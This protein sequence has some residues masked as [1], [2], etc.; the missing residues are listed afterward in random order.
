LSK[1][2]TPADVIASAS[3]P[4]LDPGRLAQLPLDLAL[5]LVRGDH[6]FTLQ[7]SG[8]AN[9]VD[10]GNN[11]DTFAVQVIPGQPSFSD[12]PANHLFYSFIENIA[13]RSIT[14]GCGS[15][16]YCPDQPVTRAQMAVFL[17][18]STR[19]LTFSPGPATGVFGD[20]APGHWAGG[21][22]EQL[23]TDGIT[24]GCGG[25][26]Y[27]PDAVVTRAQMAVFLLKAKYGAT[28]APPAQTGVFNDVPMGHW[29]GPWIER[30]AAEGITAGC[31]STTY[32][33]DNPV[34]RG[35]MTVFLTKTFGF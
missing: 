17:E 29:A 5:D 18:K 26:D 30:L 22:I 31:G 33:P 20:V 32:C 27:C 6:L 7:L 28:Y 3:V 35:Q 15:G 8:P 34:T 4:D 11:S 9:D 23:A 24:A 19:G 13:A 25:G 10:P 21:W 2:A 14:A 1:A 12:V 16:I